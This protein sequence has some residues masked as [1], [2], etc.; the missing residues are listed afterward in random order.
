MEISAGDLM[1]IGIEDTKPIK[2]FFRK[3][4]SQ[5]ITHACAGGAMWYGYDAMC[6]SRP[7]HPTEAS[8][9]M[10]HALEEIIKTFVPAEVA[11]EEIDAHSR[12]QVGY[13]IYNLNDEYDWPREKIA[14]WLDD[15]TELAYIPTIEI[16]D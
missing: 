8:T 15:L 4:D 11:P 5:R 14:E 2:E 1:R 6:K 3:T 7:L 16:D 13:A 12:V 9:T 10:P